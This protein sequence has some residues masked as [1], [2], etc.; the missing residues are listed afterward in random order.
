MA[1]FNEIADRGQL[2][3]LLMARLNMTGAA[4]APSLMPEIGPVLTLENDRF[5][6]RQLKNEFTWGRQQTVG[7]PA[8]GIHG[9]FFLINPGNSG[10]IATIEKTIFDFAARIVV[11]TA[12]PLSLLTTTAYGR[13]TDSRTPL[14]S[15]CS[16]HAGEIQTA[17]LPID[18]TYVS[19]A[20]V[21]Q[22][23][24]YVI[25]PGHVFYAYHPTAATAF[26]GACR[27]RERP[28]MP[29]ELV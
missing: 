28:A 29:G 4:P 18:R 1:V 7:A 5:E 11:A 6:W 27:W 20:N 23:N 16:W 2:T 22:D 14:Q 12:L 21:E 26:G 9:T 13:R 19:V 17:N 15:L 25:A 8:A 3:R 10:V 24:E